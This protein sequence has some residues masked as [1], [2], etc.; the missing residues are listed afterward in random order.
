VKFDG[1]IGGAYLLESVGVDAQRCVNLYPEVIESGKGKEAQVAYLKSTPGLEKILNVGLG[2][3]RAVHTDSIGRIF[4]ASG[5]KLYLAALRSEWT[6]TF[7]PKTYAAKTVTQSSGINTTTDVLTSTAHGFYTGLKV[8]V[9]SSSSLPGGLAATTD[10]WVIRVDADTFKLAANLPDALADTAVDITSTGSGNLTV[11]PQIPA[12]L[13]KKPYASTIKFDDDS[14]FCEGHGFYTG[15]KLT[16]AT[17]GVYPSPLASKTDYFVIRLNANEFQL[18]PN[19]ADAAAGITL[20]NTDLFEKTYEVDD[21][22]A[23]R[24]NNKLTQFFDFGTSLNVSTDIFTITAHGFQTGDEIIFAHNIGGTLSSPTIGDGS[25]RFV[26]KVND[27]TFRLA[28]TEANALAGTF[29]DFTSAGTITTNITR[30]EDFRA[31]NSTFPNSN[32][33]TPSGFSVSRTTSSPITGTG[34]LL[35]TKDSSDGRF[36]GV[37][38]AAFAVPAI[39]RNRFVTVT[40]KLNISTAPADNTM[41]FYAYDNTAQAP[42]T[43]AS[44]NLPTTTGTYSISFF[45]PAGCQNCSVGLFVYNWTSPASTLN[46]TWSFKID[47]MACTVST[48]VEGGAGTEIEL[49]PV[50]DDIE[51]NVIE[52]ASEG[53]EGGDEEGLLSSLSPIKAASMSAFGDGSDSSTVFVDGVSNYLFLDDPALK[54]EAFGAL[55][56]GQSAEVTATKS[57]FA[58]IVFTTVE[59]PPSLEGKKLFVSFIIDSSITL[60]QIRIAVSKTSGSFTA[61]NNDQIYLD[62]YCRDVSVVTM[63]TAELVEFLNTGAVSG[64][65]EIASTTTKRVG[66]LTFSPFLGLRASGGSASEIAI[67]ATGF[68]PATTTVTSEYFWT[69][70]GFTAF[71]YNSVEKATHIV[72]IDG[73]FIVNQGGTNKFYVSDLKGFNIDTLSFTSAEGAPDVIVGLISNQRDLWVFGE[74]SIEVY[75]NTGNADFPFERIPGGFLEVGCAAGYSVAKID[76]T[77]LWLGRSNEGQGQVF[78]ARGMTPQRVSTHAIEQAI[79]SYSNPSTA[80]AY[81]YESKGHKF[82]VLNFDEAT[83][84]YDLS[85]GL[86]HERAYTSEGNL[87]RH[88][89]GTCAYSSKAGVHLVGDHQNNKLYVMRDGYYLDDED[90]ITRLRSTPHVSSGLDRVFCPKFQV[91]MDVGVGLDGG[92]QGS[93]PQVMLDWSDDGG[94]TWSSEIWAALGRVIGGIGEFKTR[95]I[96]RRLGSFRDR[97]FR[98]KVTDPVKV[99]LLSAEIDVEKGSS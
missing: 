34:S 93:D 65:P 52:L 11:T 8:Q 58:D 14:F 73:Y 43:F 23:T 10:Y 61:A 75:T 19:L 25:T 21:E 3:I 94:H 27:N 78:A 13:Y 74:R 48:V 76:G 36:L 37:N 99:T 22:G 35:I 66:S 96:W 67:G 16:F 47:D 84:V 45:I 87:V 81:T 51:W 83:W 12:T 57:G 63:T 24:F 95:V 77:I 9:A 53:T 55:G 71:G 68:F 32:Q 5:P 17:T 70:N 1:F 30:L 80:T 41:R 4:V 69:I 2:P 7:R 91:D 40:Y 56:D 62:I 44:P 64:R 15:L 79:A 86:W 72:W 29:I 82:Y 54:I 60:G 6:V 38:L 92:G 98:L 39:A 26:I 33:S 28:T 90:P 49:S 46:A 20:V 18:A 50:S 59:D 42:I 97:I 85:T 88:R 89:A 31:P